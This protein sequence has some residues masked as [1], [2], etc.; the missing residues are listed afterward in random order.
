MYENVNERGEDRDGF[1]PIC[2]GF[3]IPVGT[4]EHSAKMDMGINYGQMGIGENEG[5]DG[6]T[7]MA[8]MGK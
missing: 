4:G 6:T 7:E 3:G 2:C 8:Y 1:Y 5:M